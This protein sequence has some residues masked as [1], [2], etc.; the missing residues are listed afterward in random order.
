MTMSYLLRNATPGTLFQKI[1][2]KA[3]D[4]LTTMTVNKATQLFRAP[5]LHSL[6]NQS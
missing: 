3:T 2:L 6:A 5:S 1:H 4:R